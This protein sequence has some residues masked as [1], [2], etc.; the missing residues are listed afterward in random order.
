MFRDYYLPPSVQEEK[1]LEFL[2]LVQGNM[3]VLQYK[4]KFIELAN[5]VP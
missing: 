5:V 3:I 1:E 2:E 4:V